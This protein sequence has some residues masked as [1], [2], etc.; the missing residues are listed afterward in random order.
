MFIYFFRFFSFYSNK[1]L[2]FYSLIRC[3]NI[4]GIWALLQVL[5][6]KYYLL[7]LQANNYKWIVVTQPSIK[8]NKNKQTNKIFT[9]LGDGTQSVMLGCLN[10]NDCIEIPRR[11]AQV[12]NWWVLPLELL[13]STG[14]LIV[15]F[16]MLN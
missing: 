6:T 12:I 16:K 15:S 2:L 1:S 5:I 10:K 8:Q 13:Y 9:V 14:L 3:Q 7:T 11:I 4:V